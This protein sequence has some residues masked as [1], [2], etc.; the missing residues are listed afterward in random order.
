[1][2]AQLRER[3]QKDPSGFF[4]E[5]SAAYVEVLAGTR[6]PEQLARWLTDKAYYDITQRA[7]RAVRHRVVTG[8]YHRPVVVVRQ[9]QVFPTDA[10]AIQGVVLLDISGA[11][12]AV[13]L[14]AELVCQRYRITEISLISS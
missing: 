9:S 8:S 5:I 10:R 11:V 2:S 3:E 1:M 14:R 4:A 7:A 13:S 12:R 6:R